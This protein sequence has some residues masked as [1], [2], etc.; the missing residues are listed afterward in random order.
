MR[1]LR[2]MRPAELHAAIERG[3]PILVPAGCVECHGNLM[4][5]GVARLIG[6]H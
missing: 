3:A 5:E 2:E 1:L 4:V 6:S